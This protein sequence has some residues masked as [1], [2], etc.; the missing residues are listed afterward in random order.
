MQYAQVKNQQK[1]ARVKDFKEIL[2]QA[3]KSIGVKKSVTLNKNPC[4]NL[5]QASVGGA[6]LYVRF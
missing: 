6:N 4:H 5:P 2:D 1:Q 3:K